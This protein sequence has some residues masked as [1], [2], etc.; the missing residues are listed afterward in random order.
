MAGVIG[1]PAPWSQATGI[2]PRSLDE[3][4]SDR[5]AGV[6]D[7]WFARLYFI[8]PLAIAGLALFWLITGL[9]AIGPGRAAAE[10][11]LAA[12]AFPAAFVA[13]AVY[14]GGWFDV[15]LGLLLP[16]R[17][18]TRGVLIVM[19]LA[20][21]VYLLLGTILAPQLW[22]DP[23]GPLVKIIPMLVATLF[24]LAILDDR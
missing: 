7:R 4:L 24:T 1:D 20:T 11:H 10:A 9:I 6:Q 16:V 2:K 18:F 14:W 15:V 21:P 22:L 13:G 23:L 8:K 3:I 5:P 12:T 19:L 17:R